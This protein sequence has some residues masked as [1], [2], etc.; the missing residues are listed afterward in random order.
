[1]ERLSRRETNGGCDNIRRP[2]V[3]QLIT[4][5][6]VYECVYNTSGGYPQPLWVAEGEGE[7][8]LQRALVSHSDELARLSTCT[9][10]SALVCERPARSK[11]N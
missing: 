6:D 8:I 10:V 2:G 3:Q 11:S 5:R 9:S 1:M 7:R 4:P